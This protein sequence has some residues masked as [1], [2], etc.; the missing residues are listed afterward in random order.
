[1]RKHYARIAIERNIMAFS[2]QNKA[3]KFVTATNDVT[4]TGQPLLRRDY[5]LA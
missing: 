5:R 2:S 4:S 3:L 1:M